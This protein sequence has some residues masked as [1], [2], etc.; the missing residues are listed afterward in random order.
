MKG[1]AKTSRPDTSGRDDDAFLLNA[2]GSCSHLDYLT[3]LVKWGPKECSCG[4]GPA[5]ILRERGVRPGFSTTTREDLLSEVGD[6]VELLAALE[7]AVVRAQ[8]RSHIETAEA[9]ARRRDAQGAARERLRHRRLA[10]A[11]QGLLGECSQLD[12]R[13]RHKLRPP[14]PFPTEEGLAAWQAGLRALAAWAEEMTR[15]RE[16]ERD[17]RPPEM[18]KR[19]LTADVKRAL[20]QAGVPH[21]SESAARVLAICW[22]SALGEGKEP[23]DAKRELVGRRLRRRTKSSAK[24]F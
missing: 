8:L 19:G 6:A 5:E 4:A 3:S 23:D 13:D 9:A 1:K 15:P 14:F 22:E 21:T 12:W 2:D 11:A 24:K 7:N 20:V 10:T 17:G 18:R 16:A